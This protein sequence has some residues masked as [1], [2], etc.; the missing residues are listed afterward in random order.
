M[1]CFPSTQ[2]W[3]G[4][5]WR[6]EFNSR[7]SSTGKTWTE[8]NEGPW[9]WWSNWSTSSV[10]KAE[11]AGPVQPGEGKA[12]G[13]PLYH[14]KGG[15]KEDRARLL[16]MAPSAKTRD[17]RH[18]LEQEG[19]IWTPGSTAV[20]CSDRSLA[21]LSGGCGPPHWDL[22]KLPGCGTAYPALG[23]PAGG[24]LGQMDPELPANIRH[25]MILHDSD[26]P[27]LSLKPTLPTMAEWEQLWLLFHLLCAA[28]L[29]CLLQQQ[30]LSSFIYFMYFSAW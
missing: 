6:A 21:Q 8:S 18:K 1:W 10:R 9:R 23:V 22:Q 13:N 12:Q 14:L 28:L 17:D 2:C 27:L 3:W 29:P 19:S 24:E 16:P 15:C 26:N 4:H 7:L 30:G 20:L 25:S 5:T 11:R